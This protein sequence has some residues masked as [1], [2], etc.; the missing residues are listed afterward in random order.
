M[1]SILNYLHQEALEWSDA[2][3]SA[4]PGRCGRL[5]RS[6]YWRGRMK[7]LGPNPSIGMGFRVLG[8]ENISIGS[9]FFSTSD[10]FLSAEEGRIVAGKY[11]ALNNNV[12]INA[13]LDGEIIIGHHVMIGPNSV[14][15]ASDH[16][17]DN[18]NV[19]MQMQGHTGGRIVL[20]D[21]VWLGA[22]V[23]VVSGVCIGRGAVVAA[24]AVVT[25][26]VEPGSIVGGVPA[27]LIKMRE[28]SLAAK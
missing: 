14:L 4:V 19:P 28:E 20:E 2:F 17:T 12:H 5:I 8:P 23:V 16:V 11:L 6:V 15:R 27:R 7:H 24:G 26:N 21:D 1:A 13:S 18:M 25:K 10:G 22:N 9:N 3:V